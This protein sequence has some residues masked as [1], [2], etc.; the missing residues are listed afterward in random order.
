[1]FLLSKFP[2]YFRAFG[3]FLALNGVFQVG[4]NFEFIAWFFCDKRKPGDL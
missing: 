2:K 1:M 4:Q 3:K